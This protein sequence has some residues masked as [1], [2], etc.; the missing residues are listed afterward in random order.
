MP[1]PQQ[2]RAEA[3]KQAGEANKA[4]SLAQHALLQERWAARRAARKNKTAELI[5]TATEAKTKKPARTGGGT[6]G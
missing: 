5:A 1:T 2:T 3:R 4:R 6:N